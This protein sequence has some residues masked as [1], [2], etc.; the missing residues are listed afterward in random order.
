[1][2]ICEYTDFT[3]RGRTKAVI[4]KLDCPHCNTEATLVIDNDLGDYYGQCFKH[5]HAFAVSFNAPVGEDHSLT[6]KPNH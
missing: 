4:L 1:M 3:G 5:N 2:S 6:R